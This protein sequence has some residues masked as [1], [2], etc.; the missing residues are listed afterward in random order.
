VLTL[1]SSDLN[2]GIV[3]ARTVRLSISSDEESVPFIFGLLRLTTFPRLRS[4]FIELEPSVPH[5][6]DIVVFDPFQAGGAS[7][8]TV[9]VWTIDR[10]LAARLECVHISLIGIDVLHRATDFLELFGAANRPGVLCVLPARVR[11]DE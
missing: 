3:A 6:E 2:L 8:H 10:S 5:K 11:L 9:Q 4:L 7:D 1:V